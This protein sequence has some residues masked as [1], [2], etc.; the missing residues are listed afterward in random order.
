VF[1][2]R[3]DSPAYRELAEFVQDYERKSMSAQ[4]SIAPATSNGANAQTR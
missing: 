1:L 3:R 4:T 2:R